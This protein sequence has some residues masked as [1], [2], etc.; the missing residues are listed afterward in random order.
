MS[1]DLSQK[2]QLN[3]IC[4]LCNY[5][6]SNKKDFSKHLL[7]LKHKNQ[8]KSTNVNNFVLKNPILKC[9]CGKIYKERTGLWRHKK[10]CKI[11]INTENL[12]KS[13]DTDKEQLILVLQKYQIN[14]IKLL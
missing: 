10:K 8:Q 12:H 14:L 4:E 7:T 13:I 9:I 5:S 6:S 2:S 11:N 1:T 3:Y